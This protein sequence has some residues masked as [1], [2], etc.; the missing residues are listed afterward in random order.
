[1]ILILVCGSGFVVC[2]R[3]EGAGGGCLTVAAVVGG[4]GGT[5]KGE[6][7]GRVCLSNEPVWGKCCCLSGGG[8]V[9][10]MSLVVAHRSMMCS[11]C[12]L[13]SLEAI[14]ILSGSDSTWRP[15]VGSCSIMTGP[16]LN[17]NEVAI[18]AGSGATCTLNL[19][20]SVASTMAGLAPS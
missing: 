6:D 1:M 8:W 9:W 20:W 16:G 15:R 11:S 17:L 5:G 18:L 3:L 4:A 10:V 12:L 19:S 7:G 13:A 2:T 14:S